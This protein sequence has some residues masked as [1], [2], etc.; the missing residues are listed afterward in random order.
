MHRLPGPRSVPAAAAY[1]NRIRLL[2]ALPLMDNGGRIPLPG[3][4]ADSRPSQ[5][6]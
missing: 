4:S 1:W 6:R 2:G 3:E 5:Y